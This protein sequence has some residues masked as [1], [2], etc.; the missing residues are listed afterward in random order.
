MQN[1]FEKFDEV[2]YD[3]Y[4]TFGVQYS[5]KMHPYMTTFRRYLPDGVLGVNASSENEARSM[6]NAT[7]GNMYAFIYKPHDMSALSQKYYPLG[8]IGK[9]E[10]NAITFFD[11]E[12]L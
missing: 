9:L 11:G 7:L 10:D 4:V 6:L 3:Y 1:N 5:Y 2:K 8:V 12:V